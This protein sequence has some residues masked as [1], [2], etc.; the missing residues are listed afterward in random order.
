MRMVSLAMM[1]TGLR[2]FLKHRTSVAATMNWDPDK[3]TVMIGCGPRGTNFTFE[4]DS[5]NSEGDP[6]TE[7]DKQEIVDALQIIV[8][9][10]NAQVE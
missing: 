1:K 8:D 3:S 4:P 7:E 9:E 2:Q 10:H 5:L 6:L